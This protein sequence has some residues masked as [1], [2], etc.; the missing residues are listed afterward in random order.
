MSTT[1]PETQ[2]APSPPSAT[3]VASFRRVLKNRNFVFLWLAQLISLTIL[4]AANFGVIV[5]VNDVTH[6]VVMAGIAIIAFTFPALPF[7]AIAGVIVDRV[8]KRLVLWVSNVLRAITVALMVISL[9]SNRTDLLP[10]YL[11]TFTTSLIGQFFI[12]AEGASI[13]LLVGESELVPALSLFNIT[14]TLSQAI[15]FLLLGSIIAHVFPP[16]TLQLATVTLHVQSIDM[17]FILVALLYLV[18]AALILCI[19]ARAFEEEHL[20]KRL[21]NTGAEAEKALVNLWRE[22]VEGWRFVRNDR[23]LFFSVVQLSVVGNIML[24]IGE[25][26]GTFVQ[27]VLRR[28]AADMAIILAPAAFGLIGASIVMP[29]ITAR[30]GKLRLTRVGFIVLGVGFSLLPVT[31]KLASNLYGEAGASSPLLLWTTVLLVFLLGAAVA[32]VNIP[33][34][35]IMQERT[36]VEARGR[37][38]S[39]QFMLYNTGSIPILL[40]AGFFAQFL[41]F[42]WLIFLV[43]ASL[44]LFCWWGKW[45]VGREA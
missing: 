16:F 43:S 12:P 40:F 21:R 5:I 8:H 4:N 27:Q 2:P 28:P 6:S 1:T 37:V 32:S 15:G 22:I 29:R 31:Q 9:L 35:T 3:H 38:F 39:L 10:L 26:A 7:G 23:L 24:L 19:P 17:L 20:N 33:T 44:L 30:V 18:C 42:N 36:P 11:L 34:Q 45:Y 25:L 13:P 14:M 41:G